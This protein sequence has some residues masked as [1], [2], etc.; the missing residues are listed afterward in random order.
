VR[1]EIG[2]SIFERSSSTHSL[3]EHSIMQV[4][5]AR[6]VLLPALL[7]MVAGA[8]PLS[9]QDA[10]WRRPD[11]ENLLYLELASGRVTIELAPRFAPRHVA[12][13]RA[14]VRGGRLEGGAVVR[15][16]D[17]Y[18]AQWRA[19]SLGSD[20]G[21]GAGQGIETPLAP[22][23]EIVDRELPFVPLPDGDVY[24][25]EVGFVDDMPV[26]RDPQTGATWIAHC[27]GSVGVARGTDPGS[28]D[29]SQLYA[30]TGHAPRHLDRNL[31][32]VGRVIDGME[33][34]STLPRGT[35]PLGYYA[36]EAE[37]AP[38]VSASIAADVPPEERPDIRILRTESSAYR[39]YLEGRR[40][41]T[42]PFFVHPVDRI[43]LCNAL[44]PVEVGPRGTR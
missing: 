30:V 26:G 15:S 6:G 19:R 25:P 27:Y 11:P 10:S 12:N 22:E 41:R 44:P 31:T 4:C 3:Q 20:D 43:G 1:D 35:E 36:T 21:A 37:E 29:G 28:G 7:A 33:H 23:F 17:N 39:V 16:Q 38:I 2:A 9:A 8:L 32:M 34:L 5:G 13:L 18:V 24:A 40:T 42:E 14:L